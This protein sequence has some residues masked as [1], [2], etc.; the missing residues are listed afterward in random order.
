MFHLQAIAPP[1][2][3][4][5]PC[6]AKYQGTRVAV[7]GNVYLGRLGPSSR[8]VDGAGRRLRQLLRMQGLGLDTLLTLLVLLG[9]QHDQAC[10]LDHGSS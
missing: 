3:N 2:Q 1:A 10:K 5:W 8:D 7:L 9:L 6:W 4:G